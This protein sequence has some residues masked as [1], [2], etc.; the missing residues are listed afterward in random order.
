[1]PSPSRRAEGELLAQSRSS[2]LRTIAAGGELPDT[3]TVSG[4]APAA[5]RWQAQALRVLDDARFCL[6]GGRFSLACFVAQQAAEHDDGFAALQPRAAPL[7]KFYVPTRY[8]NGL[9]GG[10]PAEVF[11]A[12]DA[13]GAVSLA[14]EVI[15]A[16]DAR[17]AAAPPGRSPAP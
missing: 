10:I 3:R 1:M 11:S 8:P 17:L 4:S 16:V 15:A 7:D 2:L 5:A 14:A 13:N 6:A 9:P 12:D